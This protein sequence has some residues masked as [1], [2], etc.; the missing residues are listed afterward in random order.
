MCFCGH[1]FNLP[2]THSFE[3]L[4]VVKV[5][6]VSAVTF[7]SCWSHLALQIKLWRRF[8]VLLRSHLQSVGILCSICPW[9]FWLNFLSFTGCVSEGLKV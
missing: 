6:R 8:C 9:V 2:E 5:L 7:S 3:I 1:I 4:T